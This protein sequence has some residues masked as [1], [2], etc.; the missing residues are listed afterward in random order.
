LTSFSEED[1][2]H[3]FK[4]IQRRAYRKYTCVNGVHRARFGEIKGVYKMSE[5]AYYVNIHSNS[6]T[7]FNISSPHIRHTTC[8]EKANQYLNILQIANM[9]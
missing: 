2:Y 7:F 1:S 4:R 9:K 3:V 5:V 8:N 6:N